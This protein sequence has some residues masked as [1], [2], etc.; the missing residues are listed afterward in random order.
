[1]KSK[2][3]IVSDKKWWKSELFWIVFL[4]IFYAVGIIGISLEQYR[5]YIVPLS[6]AHLFLTFLV[7]YFSRFGKKDLFLLYAFLLFFCGLLVEIVGTET[8]LLFGNY[9]YGDTLGG[10]IFGVPVI[11]G[12]NWATMVI[13]SSTLV[14]KLNVKIWTKVFLAA[15]LMTS[16]DFLI[17]PVAMKLDFWQWENDSIPIFNYVCW[18]TISLPMHFFYIKWNLVENN[19]LPKAVYIM[20]LLFFIVLNLV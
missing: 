14:Y 9:H 18:F 2:E 15:F 11:I 16:L 4:A 7:L 13:C 8:G 20:M 12:V 19:K 17:E 10:K 6:S 5:E 3:I 1:M